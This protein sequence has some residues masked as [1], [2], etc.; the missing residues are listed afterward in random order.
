MSANTLV[1]V[2][3]PSGAGKDS[4]LAWLS[5]NWD[6]PGRL[7]MARR[8]IT[9]PVQPGDEA[10]ETVTDDLFDRLLA[11]GRFAAH[12]AA[13]GLK[14]GIRSEEL[15]QTPG[16]CMF[17]N[18][19]RAHLPTALAQWPMLK[20]LYVTAPIDVLALRLKG[21][22]REAVEQVQAR[23]VRAPALPP[24]DDTRLCQ[25]CNDGPLEWAGQQ[26]LLWLQQACAPV[27]K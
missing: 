10:H 1:Y 6:G 15:R 2:A 21:R 26:A 4:L 22:G 13:N 7:R 24:V 25:V 9:R 8:T 12:W 16:T 3:G 23:L 11:D 14:Y 20:V 5:A 27:A 18:G 17:I 19:S